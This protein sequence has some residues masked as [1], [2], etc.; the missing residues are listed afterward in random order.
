MEAEKA[1]GR[2][3]HLA[4]LSGGPGPSAGW[5]RVDFV[6]DSGASATTLPRKILGA[7]TKLKKPVGYRKARALWR[8]KPG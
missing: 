7:D 6:V 1:R 5:I 2:V 8:P 3:G 4:A